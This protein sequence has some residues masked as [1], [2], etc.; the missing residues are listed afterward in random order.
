MIGG[1]GWGKVWKKSKWI[2]SLIGPVGCCCCCCWCCCCCCWLRLP[3]C[4]GGLQCC[5]CAWVSLLDQG[6][7]VTRVSDIVYNSIRYSMF[8]DWGKPQW[9]KE[10]KTWIKQRESRTESHFS[11]AGSLSSLVFGPSRLVS[12][13]C[14]NPPSSS[15]KSSKIFSSGKLDELLLERQKVP[16]HHFYRNIKI[17]I[18]MCATH[19]RL[20]DSW[21]IGSLH[22][23][24]IIFGISSNWT[25]TSL[26]IYWTS[27]EI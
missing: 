19:S 16:F 5:P 8:F 21:S 18:Y 14:W 10:V 1:V 24:M 27:L 6:I 3:G 2:I 26:R 17:F 25:L 22:L 20:A 23:R 4:W 12:C 11:R 9:I 15:G 13:W 7:P